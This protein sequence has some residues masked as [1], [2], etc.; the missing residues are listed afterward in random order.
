MLHIPPHRFWKLTP[1]E[2]LAAQNSWVQHNIPNEDLAQMGLVVDGQEPAKGRGKLT[3][4][5]HQTPWGDDDLVS[6]AMAL[7]K[8]D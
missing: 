8:D 1:L 7:L 5:G 3:D 6:R 2:F 4:K